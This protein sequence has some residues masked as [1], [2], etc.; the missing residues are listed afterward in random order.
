MK[1]F[2]LLLLFAF[3]AVYAAGAR[4]GIEYELEKDNETGVRNQAISVK[5]GWEF[6]RD[7]PIN[8]I[9]LSLERNRD[10]DADSAGVRAHET[11][12]FFRMRHNRSITDRFAYYVRGGVGRSITDQQKFN[13]GYVEPGVKLKFGTSWEWTAGVRETNSI[14][15]T[16]GQHVRKFIIGPGFSFD[17]YN[18]IEL[19]YIRGHGDKDVTSWSL[20]Y[21]HKF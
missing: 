7:S 16:S 19:R 5:P 20:G 6:S 8:L 1:W 11:K 13:Y 17:E 3:G 15:G 14:D 18:E 2:G 12:F 9:E 4:V 21:T 10:I